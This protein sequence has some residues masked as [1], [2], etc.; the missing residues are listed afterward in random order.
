MLPYMRK[1][2]TIYS[3][4]RWIQSILPDWMYAWFA[5]ATLRRVRRETG[6]RFPHLEYAM[7]LLAPRPLLMIHGGADTYIKPEMA[8]ALFALAGQPRELWL[9]DGA[10]HNQALQVANGEYRRRILEFFQRH[11]GEGAPLT[12][13]AL[14]PAGELKP[15]RLRLSSSERLKSSLPLSPPGRGGVRGRRSDR[16]SP[17]RQRGSF[18]KIPR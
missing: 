2:V 6:L 14:S 5:R 12:Q 4:R 15:S 9:V 10:K 3:D 1:W 16:P 11:L 13:P 18:D 7:P 8:Q 17:K